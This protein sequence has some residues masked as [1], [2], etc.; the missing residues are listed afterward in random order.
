MPITVWAHQVEEEDH[1]QRIVN[2]IFS[3]RLM[4]VDRGV[5]VKGE[6]EIRDGWGVGV[7]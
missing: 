7:G 3:M 1:Q 6:I 5:E 2:Q 4:D